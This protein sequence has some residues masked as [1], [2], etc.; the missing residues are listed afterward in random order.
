MDRPADALAG[1][2]HWAPD[3]ILLARRVL[4]YVGR[5]LVERDAIGAVVRENPLEGMAAV[6]QRYPAWARGPF[7]HVEPERAAP[8]APGVYALVV[9]GVVRYVGASD[10]LART[11]SDRGLGTITRRDATRAGREEHCR[12]NRLIT[13]EAVAGRTVDLYALALEG[14]RGLLGRARGERPADVAAQ[15]AGAAE[16]DW[17]LPT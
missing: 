12:L 1:G 14:G 6:E 4:T 3:H 16:G 10:D 13:A 5:L 17:H 7:G 9:A 2:D 8:S 15:V 11:F